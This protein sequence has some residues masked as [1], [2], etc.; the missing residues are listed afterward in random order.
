MLLGIVPEAPN[1]HTQGRRV[2]INENGTKDLLPGFV[3][4]E[5]RA[6][7]D[8]S[9]VSTVEHLHEGQS[10]MRV[11]THTHTHKHEHLCRN[12]NTEDSFGASQEKNGRQPMLQIG[13]ERTQAHGK[14]W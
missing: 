2:E 12:P 14:T 10:K 4:S 11:E 9:I 13:K 3:I 5:P 6:E 1:I 7:L 8:S